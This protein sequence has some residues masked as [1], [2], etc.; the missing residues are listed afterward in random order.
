M[1]LPEKFT[2]RPTKDEIYFGIDLGTTYTLVA[3]IDST[4][5][6]IENI[7]QLPVKFISYKQVSPIKHG[8]EV[9]DE[10]V[11]SIIAISNGQPF[12][13]SKLYDL[14]GH[15]DFV[16]NQNIF[17]HWKLDLGID[18]H[19]LYPDAVLK[20]LDTP[21][22]VAGKV[23]NF[24]R[25]GYTKSRDARLF[26]TVITVPASFQMNQRKDVI[27][28]AQSANIETSGQM[29]IDEP[30]AAFIGY[31]N[32]LQQQEKED[33]LLKGGNSKR[34][35]VFDIGG[36]TC[37]LSILEV[38]YSPAKGLLIG[39]KA[40]SRYNDLGGQDIDM[41]IA[42]DILYPLFLKQF[43]LKDDMPFK[44]LTEVILPQLATIGEQLKIGICNLISAKYPSIDLSDADLENTIFKLE[45]RSLFFKDKEYKFPT[46]RITA[47]QFESVVGFPKI[48]PL[49]LRVNNSKVC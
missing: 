9:I 1:Y 7:N 2:Y 10:R 48:R 39:N 24:C 40:I 17:Y 19:P 22:K 47:S 30:N 23:L 13:G 49:E 44:E 31:F 18:R 33:F 42:E 37:D 14:K 45:N 36:G 38:S 11:A 43:N 28:A 4:D 32:S 41:I 16:R 3:T 6:N 35:L 20:E 25:I 5:V 29:L 21:A 46:L 34:I 26:N 12:C 27:E 15:E 8:G